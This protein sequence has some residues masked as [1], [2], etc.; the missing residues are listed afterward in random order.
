MH[1]AHC[2]LQRFAPLDS[3][4]QVCMQTSAP[5]STMILG[6]HAV[7]AGHSALVGALAPRLDITW[8]VTP[9]SQ[10]TINS[11]L[12]QYQGRW[13]Q[14]A[15][16][17][18]QNTPLHWVGHALVS[19]AQTHPKLQHYSIDLQIDSQLDPTQGLGS[20]AALVANLVIGLHYLT[21]RSQAPDALFAQGL[22]WIHHQQ[23]RGSGADL[24]ASLLGGL[25]HFQP[26]TS[27]LWQRLQAPLVFSLAYSGYK[28]PTAEVL[29]WVEDQW[30]HDPQM[31]HQLYQDMGAVTETACH[32]LQ[33]HQLN[34]FL[35]SIETYQTLMVQLGVHTP[36]L[37]KAID[38]LKQ[39]HQVAKISGSGLGDCALGVSLASSVS[40]H[41]HNATLPVWP[42][43]ETGVSLTHAPQTTT[44]FH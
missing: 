1:D 40:R 25:V 37:A 43:A 8:R 39:Q 14:L 32:A 35:Q 5:G 28:T 24:I 27:V 6:E 4:D 21:G 10:V 41:G 42:L 33:S 15:E 31:L 18:L 26:A 9:G 19:M 2:A 23:G 29:Q 20:S 34:A 17:C 3:R 30:R 22:A 12:A 16:T 38:T 13:A 7:L 11:E 36:A 44:A